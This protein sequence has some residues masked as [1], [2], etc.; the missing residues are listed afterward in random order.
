[1][2]K[3]I[4]TIIAS[5]ILSGM[6]AVPALAAGRIGS[7]SL[8]FAEKKGEDGTIYEAELTESSNAYDIEE[9]NVSKD[10][11]EWRPGRKVTYTVTLKPTEDNFFSKNQTKI[12][13]SN[14]K[15]IPNEKISPNEMTLTINYYPR[16][17]LENPSNIYFEDE[18]TAVWDEVE[19]ATAYEVR[20]KDEESNKTNTVKVTKNE[21][22]LPNYSTD[23]NV[24]FEVR[25]CA[26]DSDDSKYIMPSQ[27]I[28]CDEEAAA[29]TN[30]T[31]AGRFEGNN[32]KRRFRDS[33]SEKYA[34]GWQLIN[35][36]WYYFDPS[37]NNYA[38][39]A[40]WKFINGKWY[41]F[42]E[43]CEMMTGWVKV[44]GKQYLLNYINGEMITGWYCNGP[45]GPW[46]Y[47]MPSGEM[48][49]NTTTPDGY[50][51]DGNG[52]WR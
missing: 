17:Q 6:L 52:E 2:R 44:N 21:I 13:V 22:D 15:V 8:N 4:F 30:N 42:N 37:N 24:S 27:W 10:Y 14:G 38:A 1:M 41:Y 46:Y 51:V 9:C 19:Y 20:I 48:L 36:S 49:S 23:N 5:T 35:G 32:E 11:S 18:Y 45:S 33:Y 50:Y 39:R 40:E 28:S 43:S 25:A 47:F 26:K 31:V 16:V 34:T 12:H 29:N 7:V 3:R